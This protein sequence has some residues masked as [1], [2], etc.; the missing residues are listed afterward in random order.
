MRQPRER[1]DTRQDVELLNA[2]AAYVRAAAGD[3]YEVAI[4][5]LGIGE[6]RLREAAVRIEEE[7]ANARSS[8]TEENKRTLDG[9][10]KRVSGMVNRLRVVQRRQGEA[11]IA[12]HERMQAMAAKQAATEQAIAGLTTQLSASVEALQSTLDHVTV[13][14]RAHDCHIA[15]LQREIA[16]TGHYFD[17]IA[18][19]LARFCADSN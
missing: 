2:L 5:S 18:G 1:S 9:V 3:D 19:T 15:E 4:Q 8:L 14:T 7:L 11:I 13:S 12:L 10:L 16:R 6:Q 17:G